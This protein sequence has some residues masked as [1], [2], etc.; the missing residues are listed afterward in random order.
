MSRGPRTVRQ[1]LFVVR[2]RPRKA[3]T[4]LVLAGGDPQFGRAHIGEL[5]W[6]V[7]GP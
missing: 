3:G 7:V 1:R 2:G 4:C 6:A 5:A